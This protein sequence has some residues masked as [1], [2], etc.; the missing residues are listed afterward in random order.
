MPSKYRVVCLC[1]AK[2]SD[3]VIGLQDMPQNGDRFQK[4]GSSR[5]PSKPFWGGEQAKLLCLRSGEVPDGEEFSSV[6]V[7]LPSERLTWTHRLGRSQ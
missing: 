2:A 5:R 7:S 6:R 4:I 3:G 1:R